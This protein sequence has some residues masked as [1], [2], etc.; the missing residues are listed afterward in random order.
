MNRLTR[1][2]ASVLA[3]AYKKVTQRVLNEMM[4]DYEFGGTEAEEPAVAHELM[5]FIV[6]EDPKKFHMFKQKVE[7]YMKAL[8]AFRLDTA[9]WKEGESQSD[10]E[11]RLHNR[12]H[13]TVKWSIELAKLV[14]SDLKAKGKLSFE[15]PADFQVYIEKK[16]LPQLKTASGKQVFPSQGRHIARDILKVLM[17]TG[18]V[19]TSEGGSNASGRGARPSES[20]L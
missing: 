15:T 10:V 5:E 2:D 17:K 4:P 18:V 12:L 19:R 14:A 20:E 16:L 1:D 8:P 9:E 3:E 11:E 13:T 6:D 7:S